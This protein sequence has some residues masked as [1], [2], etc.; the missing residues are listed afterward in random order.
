M[1]NRKNPLESILTTMRLCIGSTD[2]DVPNEEE[3]EIMKEVCGVGDQIH[4]ILDK[5][6]P[7]LIVATIALTQLLEDMLCNYEEDMPYVVTAIMSKLA[8]HGAE[9]IKLKDNGGQSDHTK[10]TVH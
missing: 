9:H 1:C 3:K 2:E 8:S 10:M 6:N 4:D 5:E 7:R